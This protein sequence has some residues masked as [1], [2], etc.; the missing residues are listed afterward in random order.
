VITPL[1]DAPLQGSVYMRASRNRLPDMG[2]DLNGQ[3]DIEQFGRI[4]SVNGRLRTT[5]EAIPDAPVTKIV[6]ELAG[7]SKGLVVNSEDLCGVPRRATVRLTGQ[8]GVTNTSRPKY[9]TPCGAKQSRK[10]LSQRW[11][12]GR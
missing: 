6:V 11:K 4:D 1:L 12:A 7:G 8:N 2:L 9:Q 10:R 5:F 3:F